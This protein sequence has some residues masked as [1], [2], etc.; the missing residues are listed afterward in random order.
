M[1]KLFVLFL[2]VALVPFSVG[3]SLWGHDE[4]TDV[5]ATKVLTLGKVF[6]ADSFVENLRP[7]AIALK[8]EM[9]FMRVNGQKLFYKGKALGENGMTVFFQASIPETT[10]ETISGKSV[11]VEVILEPKDGVEVEISKTTETIPAAAV[12]TTAP[13][14]LTPT[15]VEVS[16]TEITTIPT[17]EITEALGTDTIG[18]PIK[19][20]SITVSGVTGEV[21]TNSAAPTELTSAQSYVFT[22]KLSEAIPSTI[23]TPTWTVTVKDSAD[24]AAKTI[25]STDTNS[26]IVVAYNADKTEMTVTVTPTANYPMN[27]G[28]TFSILLSATNVKNSI[29]VALPT[30][31]FIKIK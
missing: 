14:S 6:P 10:L 31:R 26:P 8:W 7:A 15:T 11:T 1:K 22:V 20:T 2:L 16:E 5:L 21:S 23:T 30:A 12:T 29:G 27:V 25:T 3:C 24:A 9:L 17:A 4:D 13:T 19:V 18:E 28:K